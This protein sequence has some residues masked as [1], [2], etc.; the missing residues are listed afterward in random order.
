[1]SKWILSPTSVTSV[2]LCNGVLKK[3]YNFE[4]M[5]KTTH[6]CWSFILW[7]RVSNGTIINIGTII[8]HIMIML[9]SWNVNV[10]KYCRI[11]TRQCG[12]GVLHIYISSRFLGNFDIFFGI[13]LLLYS[14][15]SECGCCLID[16]ALSGL[17]RPG[18]CHLCSQVRA[19]LKSI[20]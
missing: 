19:H 20:L 3:N 18:L 16:C 13:N 12:Y 4:V 1:M 14:H 8:N 11:M 5:K 2:D 15:R 9:L 7:H 17:Q 10:R 6:F